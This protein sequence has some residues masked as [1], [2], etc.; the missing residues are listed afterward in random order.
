MKK[1]QSGIMGLSV[2]AALFLGV[3]GT[4]S[5]AAQEIPASSVMPR[6]YLQAMPAADR[7]LFDMK[8]ADS[9]E[10][11]ARRIAAMFYL[12]EILDV[13]TWDH[14][15]GQGGGSGLTPEEDSLRRGYR[16]AGSDLFYHSGDVPG[17]TALMTRYEAQSSPLRSELLDR[18]FSAAWK[19]ALLALDAQLQALPNPPQTVQAEQRAPYFANLPCTSGATGAHGKPVSGLEKEACAMAMAE[20]GKHWAKQPDGW[21]TALSEETGFASIVFTR[22]VRSLAVER[23]KTYELSAADN[24]NGFEWVGEVWF[25]SGPMREVG[26]PGPVSG[27]TVSVMRRQG[28]WSQW[29]DYQPLPLRVQRVKGKWEVDP[30]NSLLEGKQLPGAADVPIPKFAN[31]RAEAYVAS[32]KSDLRNLVTAEEAFFAYNSGKYSGTV[33]C[34]TP[35]SSTKSA[36][37]RLQRPGARAT[38]GTVN[39]CVTTGNI[40]GTIGLAAGNGGWSATITNTN[41]QTPPVTCAIFINTAPV[42]PAT[43]E[44]APACQ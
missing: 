19:A 44:G 2:V 8:V 31:T 40:L 25:S 6:G 16:S 15:F 42:A 27:R 4:L 43:T 12:G 1:P 28:Q 14:L 34:T 35:P 33:S 24:M 23:V 3:A 21:T 7:V 36:K 17:L 38:A 30:H 32:M 39:F 18:Y 11:R 20:I 26:D 22:Q 37:R 10:T 9:V 13:L 29:V 41:L 5:L